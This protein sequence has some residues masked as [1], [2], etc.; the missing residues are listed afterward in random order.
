MY[1][2]LMIALLLCSC[3]PTTTPPDLSDDQLIALLVDLHMAEMM[4]AITSDQAR[5]SV[6][7]KLLQDIITIHDIDSTTIYRNLELLAASPQLYHEI[8][9]KVAEKTK[10][11]KEGYLD[12]TSK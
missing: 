5:D 9:I 8:S 7:G 4:I 11:L 3:Q 12:E 6:S 2:T 10:T 1:K